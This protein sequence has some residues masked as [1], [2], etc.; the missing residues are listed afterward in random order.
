ML[1]R[2][3]YDFISIFICNSGILPVPFLYYPHPALPEQPCVQYNQSNKRSL[4]RGRGLL[5]QPIHII[6]F[7]FFFWIFLFIYLF[8]FFNIHIFTVSQFDS[9]ET[10]SFQSRDSFRWNWFTM[11]FDPRPLCIHLDYLMPL[12]CTGCHGCPISFLISLNFPVCVSVLLNTFLN[13][14]IAV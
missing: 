6:S 13:Y 1:N 5:N 10:N 8:F 4:W 3:V 12:V 2:I 7:F 14:L 11:T 9:N